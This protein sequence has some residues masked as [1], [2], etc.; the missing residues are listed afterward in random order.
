MLLHE[1]IPEMVA[2]LDR[3]VIVPVDS[4]TLTRI[5][6]D[7]GVNMRF[8]GMMADTCQLP[9]LKEIAIIE[10]VARTCKKVLNHHWLEFSQSHFRE[11]NSDIFLLSQQTR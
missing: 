8:L 9:H 2:A 7:Y 4:P 3:L 10:M 1:V 11:E 6:H 5:F